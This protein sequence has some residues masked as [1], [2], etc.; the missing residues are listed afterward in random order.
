MLI[1]EHYIEQNR[2]L[3]E[4]HSHYGSSGRKFANVVADMA[5]AYNTSDVLDY[6]CGKRTMESALGWPIRNYDPAIPGFDARPVPAEIVVCTDVLEHIEPEM[7]DDVLLDL[8][9]LTK[10]VCLLTIATIPSNRTL[11]DGR[12]THL[13]LAPW[14]WWLH[15]INDHWRMTNFQDFRHRFLF[16]GEPRAT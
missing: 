9:Q 4:Q 15:K 11:P 1:S 3:H 14:E 8:R 16:I 7:L 12:N 2:L 13:I 6:G 10:R 5:K